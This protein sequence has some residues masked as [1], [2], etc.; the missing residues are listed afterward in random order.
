M[1]TYTKIFKAQY[2]FPPWFHSIPSSS[3]GFDFSS[4]IKNVKRK[5]GSLFTSRCAHCSDGDNDW[6]GGKG[7][8]FQGVEGE[9]VKD[10]K[11]KME[12]W[13]H[14]GNHGRKVK[15]EL[16]T[17]WCGLRVQWFGQRWCDILKEATERKER[18]RIKRAHEIERKFVN[19]AYLGGICKRNSGPSN[20]G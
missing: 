3:S 14:G 20:S 8:D 15:E 2:E 6:D 19:N 9:A 10:F 16:D 17:N 7:A 13:R 18:R 12:P 11:V 4:L 5:V 1:K